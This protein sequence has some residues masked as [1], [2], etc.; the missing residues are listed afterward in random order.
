MS[1]K[2]PHLDTEQNQDST[3]SHV[4]KYTGLFGGV[5]GL[6]MLL[7]VVR[8]KLTA[9]FLGA[10]GVGIVSMFNNAIRL[11]S[12]STNFGLSFSA[13]K[14][15]AELFDTHDEVRIRDFCDTV[16]L[17]SLTTAVLGTI[18]ALALSPML[19]LWT[20]NSSEHT[21]DFL[22]LS[23][24]VGILA[25]VGGELAILKGLKQLKKV[26]LISVA[27]SLSTLLICTP[28]Y[29][30]WG[31]S[32]I[33]PA[34]LLMNMAVLAVN[35][36]FSTRVVPWRWTADF[37][38]HLRAGL[39]MLLLGIGYIGAGVCGQGAEY[40]IRTLIFDIDG[41]ATGVGLYQSGYT[42][43]VTYTSVVFAAIE[44]DYFPR[45]AACEHSIARQNRAVNQQIEV[46]VLLITP[47][48]IPFVLAMPLAI[49]LLFSHD[50][51]AAVPMATCATFFMFFK[52]LTLPVAY[53]PLAKGDS[54]MYV[55]T[56][57][58]YDAFVACAVPFCYQRWGLQG[59]GWALACGAL[60]DLIVIHALYRW[61]Y[62]FRLD[63]RV[64]LL[65]LAQLALFSTGL[66]CAIQPSLW[67]RWTLGPAAFALSL[68]LSLRVLGRETAILQ[69]IK[70]KL[71]RR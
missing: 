13:V 32:G 24:S 25:V 36:H 52:S 56:E 42:M 17:W 12:Q 23:P 51:L 41:N 7:S 67:V 40:L 15:V 1:R 35:L 71:R 45:L 29:W 70:D 59:A 60:E 30:L 63:R 31:A 44:A 62:H 58:V 2:S 27:T 64:V 4:L 16:R 6:T 34:L 28:I 53:L 49:W 14:H 21:A 5:Q 57:V 55:F 18:C 61:R 65:G 69:R 66:C 26:A 10:S 47:L 8:N 3:Y 22:L 39:P 9:Y 37:A 38:A 46:S 43:T 54:K 19:S 50:F 33:A 11:I 68:W 48:L 20:F